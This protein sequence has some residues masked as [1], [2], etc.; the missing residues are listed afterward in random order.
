MQQDL[1]AAAQRHAGRRRDHREG[2]VF[3]R[4]V[5]LLPGGDQLLDLAPGGDIGGEQRQAEIGADREIAALVID[6]QR[7]ELRLR[8]HRDGLARAAP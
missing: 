8:D 7:L 6:H 3:Q 1:A 2:R 5:G 4:L